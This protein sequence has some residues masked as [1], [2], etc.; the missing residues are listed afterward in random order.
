MLIIYSI[1]VNILNELEKRLLQILNQNRMKNVKIISS[2]SNPNKKNLNTKF[3]NMSYQTFIQLCNF[4]ES[5]FFC[6][7]LIRDLD[8][9]QKNSEKGNIKLKKNLNFI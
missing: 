7:C 3:L 9:N 2:K 8:N 4:F 1:L 6:Y 5:E